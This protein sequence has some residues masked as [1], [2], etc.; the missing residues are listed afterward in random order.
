MKF[1]HILLIIAVCA[2]LGVAGL[3]LTPQPLSEEEENHAVQNRK[4]IIKGLEGAE[5]DTA[6]ID[7]A[8]SKERDEQKKEKE[9]QPSIK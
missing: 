5:A 3:F 1:L 6:D 4:E 7:E 9:A 2:L 8:M